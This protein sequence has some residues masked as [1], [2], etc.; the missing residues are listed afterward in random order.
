[1]LFFKLVAFMLVVATAIYSQSSALNGH[2]RDIN[3]VACSADGKW[4]LSGGEDGMSLLWDAASRRQLAAFKGE[5][6]LAVAIS[7]GGKRIAS[8]ERYKKVR[9]LDSGAKE[10]R[11]LEGHNADILAVSF[12]TDGKLLLSFAKDGGI[13]SWEATTGA[14]QGSPQQV[15]DSY[16]SGVFSS[17]GKWLAGGASATLYF[18]NLTTKKLAWKVDAGNTVKAVAISPDA[19]TIAVALGDDT[20]R[21][22]DAASGKERGKAGGIDANGVEFSPDGTRIAVAGHDNDVRVPEYSPS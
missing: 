3:A 1:M 6:V 17:D 7:P 2:T 8:G 9:L 10:I 14:P 5:A 22:L 19:R 4:I 16:D 12:T 11:T 18:Y 21:V 13:R 15:P 20:V